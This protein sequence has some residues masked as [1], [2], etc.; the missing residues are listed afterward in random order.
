MSQEGFHNHNYLRGWCG[1]TFCWLWTSPLCRINSARICPL[2]R[3]NCTASCSLCECG[4]SSLPQLFAPRLLVFFDDLGDLIQVLTV[5][6]GCAAEGQ[7]YLY[8]REHVETPSPS[9]S[10]GVFW[11]PLQ[12]AAVAAPLFCTPNATR[13]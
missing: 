10:R 2:S 9:F 11:P 8:K 7:Q 4:C 13:R 1:R 3:I 6:A 5:G 12:L